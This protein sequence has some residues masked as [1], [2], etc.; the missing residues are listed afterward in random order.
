MSPSIEELKQT[1]LAFVLKDGYS[2][3]PE[4]LRESLNRFQEYRVVYPPVTQTQPSLWHATCTHRSYNISCEQ[5]DALLI[6]AQFA[7]Q[8]C[9]TTD[10]PLCIDHD[11]SLG[12]WAVRG[13]LCHPCNVR[14]GWV[15][16]G[17]RAAT[18]AEA[19]YLASPPCWR[20]P[21]DVAPIYVWATVVGRWESAYKVPRHLRVGSGTA[22]WMNS[23]IRNVRLY[24]TNTRPRHTW[25]R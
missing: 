12:W 2:D 14:L 21:Y 16:N 8:I 3:P 7:C 18:P 15:D 10:Q 1:G 23:A 20:G 6:D 4:Y 11:H 9:R 25:R 24:G 17:R 13:L 19:A 5:F 22:H